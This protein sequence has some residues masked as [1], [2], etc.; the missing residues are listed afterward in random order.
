M[1]GNADLEFF[2]THLTPGQQNK[3]VQI[4]GR[5]CIVLGKLDNKEVNV[6]WDTGAQ[7]SIV[8][9]RFLRQR[10]PIKQLRNLSELVENDL[11]LTAAMVALY[12]ILVGLN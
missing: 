8:S 5:K 6:L 3:L 7:V 10:H 9:E 12:H 4:I 2:A 11:K 1:K